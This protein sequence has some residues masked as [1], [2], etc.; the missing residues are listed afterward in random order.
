VSFFFFPFEVCCL[1]RGSSE[2][3][4]LHTLFMAKGKFVSDGSVRCGFP[5][6]RGITL[7]LKANWSLGWDLSYE[8][9][10]VLY[11]GRTKLWVYVLGKDQVLL[12]GVLGYWGVS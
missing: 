10:E 12:I 1:E 8:I 3:L 11:P 5:N 9:Y 2:S 6:L 7:S 4:T